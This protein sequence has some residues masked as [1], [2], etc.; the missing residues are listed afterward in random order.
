MILFDLCKL[1][2]CKMM[3][4]DVARDHEL[5]V[6][7]GRIFEVPY[8]VYILDKKI[9]NDNLKKKPTWK[10]AARNLPVNEFLM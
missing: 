10:N 4:F 2:K 7:F 9:R 5:P 3:G 1:C 6:G 8:G